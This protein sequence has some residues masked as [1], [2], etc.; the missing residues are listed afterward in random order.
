[1]PKTT[2]KNSIWR[3][4]IN[5]SDIKKF[6]AGNREPLQGALVATLSF[7]ALLSFIAVGKSHKKRLSPPEIQ[8]VKETIPAVLPE[9]EI[10][11]EEIA[12]NS[13]AAGWQTY[14]NAWYGFQLKY[15]D[16]WGKPAGKPRTRGVKWEYRYTFRKKENSENSLLGFDVVIYDGKA[17]KSL[18]D[19][20]EI[21]AKD[22]SATAQDSSAC[23]NIQGHLAEYENFS[24]EEISIGANDE[25][26][27]QN[28]FFSLTGERYIYN[29]VPAKDEDSAGSAD[30]RKEVLKSYPE[31]VQSAASFELIAIKS[32]KPKPP[33][34]TARRPV[35]AKK[36][37][38]KLVCAKK[39]DKPRESKKTSKKHLDLECC[40][41]PDEYPNPWCTY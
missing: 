32:P 22:N 36:V 19:T 25:C 35:A 27:G 1:M 33:A 9:R 14:Q 31:F 7:F 12:K 26:F 11:V 4:I 41:D 39:N 24:A 23:D 5:F 38:G 34:P 8:S 13:E 10:S 18:L 30:F 20:E 6:I 21:T 40:L 2:K 28:Y 3:Q 16:S 17:K 37:N 15:P 29:I